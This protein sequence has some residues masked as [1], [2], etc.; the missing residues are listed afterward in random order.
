MNFKYMPEITWP[1]GYPMILG[2]M[3]GIFIGMITYF[4]RKDW[5]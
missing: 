1:Y 4:R 5:F 3:G 2:I